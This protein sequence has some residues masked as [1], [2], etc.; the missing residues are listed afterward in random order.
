MPL[1]YRKASRAFNQVRGYA[2]A[3]VLVA[4]LIYSSYPTLNFG[5]TL[6][7]T[8][9]AFAALAGVIALVKRA[10]RSPHKP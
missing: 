2:I 7:A 1:N 9:L 5:W 4:F 10:R 6:A 3:A 8:A